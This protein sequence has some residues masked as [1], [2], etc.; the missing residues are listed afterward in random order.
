MRQGGHGTKPAL[1]VIKC[2]DD[3]P[4]GNA[5]YWFVQAFSLAA[6]F[7]ITVIVRGRL[8]KKLIDLGVLGPPV[9]RRPQSHTFSNPTAGN[10]KFAG[11]RRPRRLSRR[12]C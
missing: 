6:L 8:M 12:D 9:N 10:P 4:S 3:H 7:A 2:D 11:F 5:I 1:A